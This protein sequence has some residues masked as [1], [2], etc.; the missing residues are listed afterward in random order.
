MGED[1]FDKLRGYIVVEEQE[2]NYRNGKEYDRY[3][4]GVSSDGVKTS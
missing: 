4:G 3:W 1:D 2:E